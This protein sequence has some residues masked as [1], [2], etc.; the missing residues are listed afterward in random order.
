MLVGDAITACGLSLEQPDG[1][2]IVVAVH[3]SGRLVHRPATDVAARSLGRNVYQAGGVFR[4]G[5]IVGGRGRSAENLARIVWLALDADLSDYLGWQKSDVWVLDDDTL[6]QLIEMQ[7]GDL[8]RVLADM[9][10]T[11]TRIDYTGYGL[12]GYLYLD[13]LSGRRVEEVQRIYKALVSAV[14]E[15]WGRGNLVDPQVSDAGTRITRIPGSINDKGDTPRVSRTLAQTGELYSL[16]QLTQ[17]VG[18]RRPNVT[19]IDPAGTKRLTDEQVAQIVTQL[20]PYWTEGRRHIVALG[21]A[22]MLAKAGVAQDQALAIVRRLCAETGD[23]D[24]PDRERTV[25]TTYMR[26]AAGAETAGYFSLRGRLPD[27]V[28]AWLDQEL[29]RLREAT[30]TV[31]MPGGR[32]ER[33]AP[34]VPVEFEPPP[35]VAMRGWVAD[36]IETVSPT[37]EAVPAFHL[38]CGLAVAGSLMGRRVGLECGEIV[39]PNLFLLLVGPSGNSRKDTAIKRALRL[40]SDSHLLGGNVNVAEVKIATDVASSE[41]ITRQLSE[42]PNSLLYLT[43]FSKAVNNSRRE[44][45][46]TIT[47]TLMQAWD[48]P[49]VMQNM[50]KASPIEARFPFL[51]ILAATQP[52]ILADLMTDADIYSGFANRFLFICGGKG[53]PKPWPPALSKAD[54][55]R[56]YLDVMD[57]IKHYGEGTIGRTDEADAYWQDWYL[58]FH[59]NTALSDEESAMVTRHPALALKLALIYAILDRSK[60][61]DREHLEIGT[62]IVEW[63]WRNIRPMLPTWG[64]SIDNKIQAKIIETLRARGPMSRRDLQ[65]YAKGR[66]SLKDYHQVFEIMLKT[67]EILLD[68]TGRVGLADE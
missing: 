49:V 41:G 66:R 38:G 51:S 14:N 2:L 13:E 12:C 43:E 40:I 6:M 48:T 28:L 29:G 32:V 19:R 1:D 16:E 36:Y 9:G 55:G 50:T 31:I 7:R 26:R 56:L 25:V 11:F 3:E 8:E 15:R 44:G 57:A 23:T 22:G 10:L 20:A 64:G 35:N 34:V 53:E 33:P 68:P 52:E 63:S 4:P 59:G 30:V 61:I 47:N 42:H 39:Y 58:A 27:T 54:S 18:Q 67:G 60:R 5:S 17:A 45:T 21:L 24:E 62:A 65:R 37:T 46:K